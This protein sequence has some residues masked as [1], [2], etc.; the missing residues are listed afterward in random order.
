VLEGRVKSLGAVGEKLETGRYRS[1][2]KLDD[3]VGFT[4][5]VPTASHEPAVL[6]KLGTVFE[7]KDVKGRG[8]AQKAPEIFRFDATRWYGCVR[9]GAELDARAGEL[10]FEVQI[11]TAFEHAWSTVT[12]DLVYKGQQVDWRSKRLA[13]QLKALVEQIDFLVNQFEVAAANIEPSS[14][15]ATDSQTGITAICRELL[16][17]GNLPESLEPESW[18]RFAECVFALI[19]RQT[20]NNFEAARR[21]TTS[22]EKFAAAVRN[23][24]FLPATSGSL[25]QCV[26]AY[27]VASE[28]EGALDDF[29]IA[30]STE[31][32]DLYGISV[33]CKLDLDA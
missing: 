6:T 11:K 23:G 19:R 21:A 24:D 10:I 7:K 4:V 32:V 22:I 26:V 12:H 31:L 1:W 5:V 17:E 27:V 20:R 13:A 28:G 18:Q 29:P 33:P 16:A 14:D 8:T 9:E 15:P 30:E 25:F 2:E 3:L